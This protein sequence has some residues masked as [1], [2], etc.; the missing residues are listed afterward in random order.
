M[1][2]APQHGP[3]T[4]PAE[5]HPGETR[6]DFLMLAT[7]AFGAVG[8]LAAIFPLI[9]QM[10]PSKDV[11]AVATTE[12]DLSKIPEGA[13]ITVVWR[14]KPVFVWHRTPDAI[15]AAQ[16]VQ[17]ASLR[18]PQSDE[19]RAKKPEW[20]VVVGICTHLGCIPLGQK[21]NDTKGEFGGWFCPCH[22]SIYD[23][24]GRIRGGPAPVNLEVPAYEILEN[25]TLRIG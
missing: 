23:S 15:K 16:D 10:N 5:G 13:R 22:G 14:G 8:G 25:N 20:L 19:S 2:H 3:E 21:P 9:H 6:R 17:L 18:D 24:S 7:A 1:A 12:V 11:L 4:P